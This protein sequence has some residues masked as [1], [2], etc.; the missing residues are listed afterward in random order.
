MLECDGLT[1]QRLSNAH[2]NPSI[3]TP[4]QQYALARQVIRLEGLPDQRTNVVFM[5]MVRLG[6]YPALGLK[7][8]ARWSFS[9]RKGGDARIFHTEMM[10]GQ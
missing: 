6:S 10:P 9:P 1:L 5:G 2:S 4:K 3:P 8:A 7:S